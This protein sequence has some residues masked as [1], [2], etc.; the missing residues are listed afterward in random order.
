MKG[1][2]VEAFHRW[3]ARSFGSRDKG[4]MLVFSWSPGLAKGQDDNCMKEKMQWASKRRKTEATKAMK[5]AAM[6]GNLATTRTDMMVRQREN[7]NPL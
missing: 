5:T 7:R 1:S 3:V 2:D 4:T 6:L